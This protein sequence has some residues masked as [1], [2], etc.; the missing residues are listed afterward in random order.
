MGILR[1]LTVMAALAATMAAGAYAGEM[2]EV[3]TM[4]D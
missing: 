1:T 3:D 4:L 2:P